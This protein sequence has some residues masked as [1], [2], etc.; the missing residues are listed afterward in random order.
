MESKN[1]LRFNFTRKQSSQ[2]VNVIL[3]SID[4]F[5]DKINNTLPL[6]SVIGALEIAKH[7]VL[8]FHFRI[9]EELE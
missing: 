5:A 3:D 8:D 6:T 7:H 1:Q 2:L 9:Q 4:E